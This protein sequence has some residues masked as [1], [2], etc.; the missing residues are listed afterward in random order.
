LFF[1]SGLG[2]ANMKILGIKKVRLLQ[3][4]SFNE[5]PEDISILPITVLLGAN[6]C[7]KTSIIQSLLL[8]KQTL[9]FASRD[10]VLKIDT[11][12]VNFS[13]IFEATFR[14]PSSNKTFDNPPEILEKGPVFIIE[15][16]IETTLKEARSGVTKPSGIDTFVDLSQMNWLKNISEDVPLLLKTRIEIHFG[17]QDSRVTIRNMKLNS[18]VNDKQ[19]PEIE[20]ISKD[21]KEY[22]SWIKYPG[23]I[24]PLEFSQNKIIVDFEHF[25]PSFKSQAGAN[26]TK[27]RQLIQSYW[28]F[29][30][31]PFLGLIK[32][33]KNIKYLGPL[34]AE[35]KRFY[36]HQGSNTS[37][38]IDPTGKLAAEI[39][40]QEKG[41]LVHYVPFLEIKDSNGKNE[42]T[43][44]IPK[45]IEQNKFGAVVNEFLNHLGFREILNAEGI[46]GQVYRVTTNSASTIADVGFGVSQVFPLIIAGLRSDWAFGND[47]E[48][49]SLDNYMSQ[50]SVSDLIILEQP[51][52]HLHPKAQ[53]RLAQVLVSFALAGRK[54][55]VET[56]SDHLIRRFRGLIARTVNS[57]DENTL[58]N[59][60]NII[61]FE[62]QPTG[63]IFN[64]IALDRYGK[65]I[66]SNDRNISDEDRQIFW[67][68]GFMDESSVEEQAIFT[69]WTQKLSQLNQEKETIVSS[70][71]SRISNW[72]SRKNP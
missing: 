24:K 9:E 19:G 29:F 11:P 35:P 52:I 71:E 13:N 16:E 43:I 72:K 62:Y 67:P 45:N 54:F 10:T 50:T 7:G 39:L 49:L 37:G 47:L 30:R 26:T 61:N 58:S 33:I 46:W 4:K 60:I 70:K 42:S 63:T 38:S 51:E 12:Y 21:N 31:L 59:L 56:H 5:M 6:S 66:K 2:V 3:F 1:S 14:A 27:V 53:S 8:L 17:W 32:E 20:I 64:Q 69:A 48:N 57:D 23:Q 28:I 18:T 15:W 25:L 22:I 44:C 36:P 40:A 41:K 55:I 68:E 65:F 34:R